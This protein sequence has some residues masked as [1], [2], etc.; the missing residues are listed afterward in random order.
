MSQNFEPAERLDQSAVSHSNN[1]SKRLRYNRA[2]GCE[3]TFRAF[4]L[5][6]GFGWLSLTMAD[7]QVLSEAYARGQHTQGRGWIVPLAILLLGLGWAAGSLVAARIVSIAK[8]GKE[9]RSREN[10][11]YWGIIV[12]ILVLL[13]GLEILFRLGNLE[14]LEV[15]AATLNPKAVLAGF[16]LRLST[17]GSLLLL[18]H[19][20]KS[21]ATD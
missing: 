5:L 19:R 11:M 10:V 2:V 16:F 13:L 4:L 8:H 20:E 6:C 12:G 18:I 3:R 14:V 21:E 7:V 15:V 1:S 9:K 17:V